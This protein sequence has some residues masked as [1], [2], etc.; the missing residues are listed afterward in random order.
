MDLHLLGAFEDHHV[1]T[2]RRTGC[3]RSPLLYVNSVSKMPGLTIDAVGSNARCGS[4]VLIV[5]ELSTTKVE[6]AAPCEVAARAAA[7]HASA[8]NATSGTVSRHLRMGERLK[9]ALLLLVLGGYITLLDVFGPLRLGSGLGGRPADWSQQAAA[10]PL[11]R[12]RSGGSSTGQRSNAYG[13][14]G[15]KRQPDGG[16]AGF[17]TSPGRL[18]GRTPAPSARGT[19]AIRASL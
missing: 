8:S 17:G 13:Q 19:A 16:L 12:S 15:W 3:A 1:D 4:E 14:R 2:R 18:S 5:N 9:I 6:F 10:R 11:A 7:V